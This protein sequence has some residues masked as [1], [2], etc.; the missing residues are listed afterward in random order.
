MTLL[1]LFS[2][3]IRAND[4]KFPPELIWWVN[5]IK[6][7]N[8]NIAIEDFILTEHKTE[9][10]DRNYA[11]H[12]NNRRLIYPVFMRWNYSGD[13]VAYLDFYSIQ[14]IRQLSGKYRIINTGDDTEVLLIADKNKNVFYI[15]GFGIFYGLDAIQWL[16]DNILIG[17]GVLIG[18]N[19]IDLLIYEYKINEDTIEIKKYCYR[20]A[21]SIEVWHLLKLK[22]FEQRPDYFEIK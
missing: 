18:D 11:D 6:K 22:W 1:T 7:G 5:E 8:K 3:I 9:R 2:V 17:V 10:I 14:L 20:N 4:I 15:D 19:S 16:N 13:Y 12:Q 21:F